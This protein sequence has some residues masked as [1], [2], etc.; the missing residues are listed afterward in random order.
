MTKKVHFSSILKTF[1]CERVS[2]VLHLFKHFVLTY[3]FIDHVLW[4]FQVGCIDF[5]TL[6]RPSNTFSNHFLLPVKFKTNLSTFFRFTIFHLS[7]SNPTNT[8]DTYVHL[9]QLWK[10]I[11]L[12]LVFSQI[13]L[14][15]S[16]SSS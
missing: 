10:L 3:F 7:L 13:F 15:Y 5:I 2:Q 11:C 1:L 14:R 16:K 6:W 4:K 12:V 9:W 8:S